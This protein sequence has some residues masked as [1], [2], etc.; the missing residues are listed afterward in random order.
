M[1]GYGNLKVGGYPPS[2]L[3]TY[4]R[5]HIVALYHV[6]FNILT[7]TREE[8]VTRTYVRSRHLHVVMCLLLSPISYLI[9]ISCLMAYVRTP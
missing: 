5:G 8:E 2:L 3:D 9:P 1:V 4:L 6:P 7:G